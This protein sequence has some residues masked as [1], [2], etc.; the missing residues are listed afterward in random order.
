[1]IK[2]LGPKEIEKA[3][4]GYAGMHPDEPA[5]AGWAAWF[6]AKTGRGIACMLGRTTCSDAGVQRTQRC[7]SLY[8]HANVAFVPVLTLRGAAKPG[9]LAWRQRYMVLERT[10]HKEIAAHHQVW[11][12]AVETGPVETRPQ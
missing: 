3:K 6:D 11:R 9:T 7:A 1:M 2:G 8:G 12:R 5:E 10:T 4:K